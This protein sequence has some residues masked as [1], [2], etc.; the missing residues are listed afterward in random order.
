MVVA[1]ISEG[2]ESAAR[3]G[4]ASGAEERRIAPPT[5]AASNNVVLSIDIYVVL[6]SLAVGKI[7]KNHIIITYGYL[8]Y[9]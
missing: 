8:S 2:N 7:R 5:T 3:R 1:G 9:T 6:V 4:V